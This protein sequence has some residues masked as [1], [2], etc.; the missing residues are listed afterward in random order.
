MATPDGPAAGPVQHVVRRSDSRENAELA[1]LDWRCD[2]DELDPAPP[3]GG[4]GPFARLAKPSAASLSALEATALKDATVS[5]E[6]DQELLAK[7]SGNVGSM[8]S[9]ITTLMGAISVIYE[10]DVAVHE[11]RVDGAAA[12]LV[13]PQ[14]R[15]GAGVDEADRCRLGVTR[16]PIHRGGPRKL[17]RLETLRDLE[18]HPR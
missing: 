10:R 4:G 17:R 2:A 18:R 14:Q 15:E 6:T 1:P 5:I 13:E 11:G 12:E 8:T 3:N 9:Y 16:D 7:F